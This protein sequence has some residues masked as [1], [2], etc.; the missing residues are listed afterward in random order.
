MVGDEWNDRNDVGVLRAEVV[1][2][3]LPGCEYITSAERIWMGKSM[4]IRT[5]YARMSRILG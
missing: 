4:F 5:E 2:L 1:E 3:R